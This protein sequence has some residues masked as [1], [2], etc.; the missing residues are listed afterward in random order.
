VAVPVDPLELA[1]RTAWPEEL[2]AHYRFEG[3]P[4]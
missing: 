3:R 2:L 1:I 4:L